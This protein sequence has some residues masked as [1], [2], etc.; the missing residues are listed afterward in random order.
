MPKS[1]VTSNGLK[2][3]LKKKGYKPSSSIAEYIWNGFEADSS[4]VNIVASYNDLGGISSF[5]IADNGTGIADSNSF[6]PLFESEKSKGSYSNSTSKRH[7]VNNQGNSLGRL[8]FFTFAQEATWQTVY[9]DKNGVKYT[10]KIKVDSSS[11]VKWNL[12]NPEK[13]DELTG[14]SVEFTGI[15]SN[16]TDILEQ[17]IIE[18]LKH[19]FSWYLK[20]S[21]DLKI[22]INDKT[23]DYSDVISKEASEAIGIGQYDFNIRFISWKQKLNGEYSRYYFLN[24]ENCEVLSET[25]TLNNKGDK[26]FRV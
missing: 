2:R 17:D 8:T 21:N 24:T 9:K 5:Y 7:G 20:Q 4:C 18:Y 22:I 3:D 10:Y 26:F 16:F 11:L 25:T 1:E 13:T 14:T 19:E 15:S 12:T 6:N 23:L